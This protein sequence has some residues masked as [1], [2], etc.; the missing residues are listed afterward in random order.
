MPVVIVLPLAQCAPRCSVSRPHRTSRSFTQR[1]IRFT[2]SASRPKRVRIIGCARRL[3]TSAEDTRPLATVSRS[4]NAKPSALRVVIERS[5][6]TTGSDLP[7]TSAPSTGSI[8]AAKRSRSGHTTTMS[9]GLREGS[10]AII[11]K[12]ASRSTSTW[13]VAPWHRCT[14]SERSVIAGSRFSRS[15]RGTDPAAESDAMCD[16]S[17]A[18]SEVLFAIGFTSNELAASR[19][20]CTEENDGLAHCCTSA[21]FAGVDDSGDGAIA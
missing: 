10:R 21:K 5:A 19:N 1:V 11:W 8:S 6:I 18:N 15:M 12:I 16:F 20:I 17:F 9:R 14:C 7:P 4:L 2:P 13:R 3:S